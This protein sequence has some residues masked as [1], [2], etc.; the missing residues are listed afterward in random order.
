M[1]INEI[2]KIISQ[3]ASS[4]TQSEEK[5]KK[6]NIQ[7]VVF[8]LD[9]EE[10]AVEITELQEIIKI[11]AITPIP[12]CPEFIK[13]ILNL[14]GKIVVVVDLEKR[15]SLVKEGQDESKHIII[16]EIDGNNYGVLVDQVR[17]VLLVPEDNIQP[18]PELVSAKI[19]AD[20]LGGVIVFEKKQQ[21]I[22]ETKSEN[23]SHLI[24][25]LNLKKLL[26][27]KELMNLGEIIKKSVK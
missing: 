16:T 9:Q 12:N 4:D 7:V 2:Q 1:A 27:E 24:I 10:Y 3:V 18:T 11:P 21:D 26:Q 14:R 23:E 15:F 13:G 17:E 20:Y 8:G 22:K 19:D 6:Q 25:L 5:K